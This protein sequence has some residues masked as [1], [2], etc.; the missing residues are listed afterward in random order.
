LA[1]V[2]LPK[3]SPRQPA[4]FSAKGTLALPLKTFSLWLL[5][6]MVHALQTRERHYVGFVKELSTVGLAKLSDSKV[7]PM[8]P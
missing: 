8:T 2:I 7:H 5:F 4:I 3:V 6:I 1:S